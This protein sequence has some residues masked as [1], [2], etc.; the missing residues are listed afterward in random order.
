MGGTTVS[1]IDAEIRPSKLGN[2]VVTTLPG[3]G[4]RHAAALPGD[5]VFL[6][7]TGCSAP[8]GS[9]RLDTDGLG[10]VPCAKSDFARESQLSS[11]KIVFDGGGRV[12]KI[13]SR[14]EP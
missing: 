14:Y 2:Q 8:H 1:W 3:P 13:A 11:V 7:P 6:T 12:V 4:H 5:A 9:V 10:L